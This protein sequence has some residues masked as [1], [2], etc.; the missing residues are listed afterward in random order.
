[1]NKYIINSTDG[2]AKHSDNCDTGDLL[3]GTRRYSYDAL[4]FSGASRRQT[5]KQQVTTCKQHVLCVA[6]NDERD[7]EDVKWRPR[8]FNLL[9]CWGEDFDIWRRCCGT[10]HFR[11]EVNNFS[12]HTPSSWDQD[13]SIYAHS[14]DNW[15]LPGGRIY[16]HRWHSARVHPMMMDSHLEIRDTIL[17]FNRGQY[18]CCCSGEGV[19]PG[20]MCRRWVGGGG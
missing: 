2:T 13:S 17:G 11:E 6:A 1:M 12:D 4:L 10:I 18:H 19:D 16:Q 7:M 14:T 15:L 8:W 20:E 5:T 3:S 9:H